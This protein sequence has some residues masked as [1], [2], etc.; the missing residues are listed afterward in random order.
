M[1]LHDSWGRQVEPRGDLFEVWPFVDD[2]DS[3]QPAGLRHRRSLGRK[4]LDRRS[5]DLGGG[6]LPGEIPGE[7][8]V[9]PTPPPPPPP[10]LPSASPPEP[11]PAS[12]RVH[13]P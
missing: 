6:R 12:P 7:P 3:V 10:P 11:P 2:R 13:A 1:E 4:P 5:Q 8:G 9:P